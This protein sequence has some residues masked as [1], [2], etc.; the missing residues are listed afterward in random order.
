MNAKE[1]M[2]ISPIVPVIAIDNIKDALPLAKALS[3]GGI[4][5]MEITLRT[6]VGLKAIEIISKEFPSMHVGAGTVCTHEDLV[7]AKNAGAQF[8]FSPGISEELIV[9]AQQNNMIL[10][11]GVSTASEVMMA[12]NYKHYY[13]K[14]FPAALSGGVAILKAF[15]GPFSRMNFCP[16]GGVSLKNCKE[17]LSLQ[18]VL[19]VGGTWIVP[20]D[21][22]QQGDFELITKLSLEALENI[23]N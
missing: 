21:A 1:L 9:S 18:N 15:Q 2:G 20:K 12:Q 19:C 6:P 14:L 17:F 22:I 23:K 11:P 7:N 10:I 16:T 13:C 4:N 3:A 5:I 8:V